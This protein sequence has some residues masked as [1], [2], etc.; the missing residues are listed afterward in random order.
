MNTRNFVIYLIILLF[1]APVHADLC[2][3]IDRIYMESKNGFLNWKGYFDSDLSEYDSK[4]K[5]QGANRCFI[6]IDDSSKD[7]TCQWSLQTK[8]LMYANYNAFVQQISV[9]KINNIKSKSRNKTFPD[10]DTNRISITDKSTT[11]FDFNGDIKLSSSI[12]TIYSK[13]RN[14]FEYQIDFKLENWE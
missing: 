7:F 12:N 9:C 6:E 2:S 5:L 4:Y 10:T 14:S 1:C 3:E 11:Y 13:K 8:E